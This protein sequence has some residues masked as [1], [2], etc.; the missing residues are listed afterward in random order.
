[1][2]PMGV[3]YSQ[4]CPILGVAWIKCKQSHHEVGRQT[5][6]NLI[7]VGTVG[8][9]SIKEPIQ[10][11][12]GQMKYFSSISQYWSSN[13]IKTILQPSPS[14]IMINWFLAKTNN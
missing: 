9:I 3:D 11:K 7:K 4:M 5:K 10:N 13:Y 12:V 2:S 8:S 6:V 14:Y 1:M